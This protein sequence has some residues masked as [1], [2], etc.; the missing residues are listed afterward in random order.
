MKLLKITKS[1]NKKKKWRAHFDSGKHTDF[2]SAG[3]EDYTQHHDK[4]RRRRY[5]I[6]HEKDLLT[7]DPTRA[8]FLSFYILWGP[9][10]DFKKNVLHYKHKFETG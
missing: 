5:L 1:P 9:H 10:T 7:K 2:G 3:M 4:E 8:G 6:R